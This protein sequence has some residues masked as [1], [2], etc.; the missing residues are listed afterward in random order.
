MNETGLISING[1]QEKLAYG[2]SAYV[3]QDNVL[4]STLSVREAVYYSAQL[5]L[6]D[7]MPASEKRAHADRV[8][9]ETGLGDAMDTRIG[10]AGSPRASAAGSGSG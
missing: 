5:Q 7:T 4:M 10:V 8:I 6:P 3:T 9:R 2:T 1:R